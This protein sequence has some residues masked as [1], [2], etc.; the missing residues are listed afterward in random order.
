MTVE[1]QSGGGLE[2]VQDAEF[3]ELICTFG[4]APRR[5]AGLLGLFS[6][7]VSLIAHHY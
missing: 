1:R 5:R 4:D 7:V 3:I 6:V 2:I